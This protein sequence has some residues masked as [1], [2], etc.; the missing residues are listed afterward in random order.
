MAEVSPQDIASHYYT[1]HPEAYRKTIGIEWVSAQCQ[2]E[3][4]PCM[5]GCGPAADGA[6]PS[7][8]LGWRTCAAGRRAHPALALERRPG[9]DA[10]GSPERSHLPVP[11]LP[12]DWLLH[13]PWLSL[14]ETSAPWWEA[15]WR[16]PA[17]ALPGSARKPAAAT[18]AASSASVYVQVTER[19]WGQHPLDS[20]TVSTFGPPG[21]G[22]GKAAGPVADVAQVGSARR[23]GLHRGPCHEQRRAWAIVAGASACAVASAWG[24]GPPG[25]SAWEAIRR[26]P[27]PRLWWRPQGPSAGASAALPASASLAQADRPASAALR[28]PARPRCLQRTG[29]WPTPRSMETSGRRLIV[30]SL[31]AAP[32]PLT[33]HAAYAKRKR[34]ADRRCWPMRRPWTTSCPEMERLLARGQQEGVPPEAIE[35][36]AAQAAGLARR[37]ATARS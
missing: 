37:Q 19:R 1:A 15:A 14:S 2:P 32:A 3:T 28:R 30:R 36:D 6:S 34:E 31:A 18:A 8:A 27:C 9:R 21:R 20:E 25:W 23:R 10:G 12:R 22:P 35:K 29:A 13:R 11:E 4:R 5:T 7:S 24:H 17:V 33:D 26:R 16:A